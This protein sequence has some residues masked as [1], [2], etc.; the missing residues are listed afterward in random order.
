MAEE[1]QRHSLTMEDRHGLKLTGVS[2]AVSFEEN[3]V[4]LRTGLGMLHVHGQ[5]LQLKNL[6]LEKGQAA[7]EG[8]I[9]ALIYEEPRDRGILGR[10][11]R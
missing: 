5:Q 1:Q 10:F 11:F 3:L 6:C 9:A 2:E 8:Q 4:V 7:V